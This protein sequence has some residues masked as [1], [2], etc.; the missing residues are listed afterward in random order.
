MADPQALTNIKQAIR[1]NLDALVT[2]GS[3][4]AVIEDDF[5]ENLLTMNYPDFPCA[6]LTT[7]S[8]ESYYDTSHENRRVHTFDIIIVEKGE[9]VSATNSIEATM[10]AIFDQFDSDPT[11]IGGGQTG[12]VLTVEPAA[13]RAIPINGPDKTYIVFVLTLKVTLITSYR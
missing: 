10:E 5:K 12:N 1:D 4:G 3:L 11:L 8:T 13:S 6:V 2:A 7:P 9:N